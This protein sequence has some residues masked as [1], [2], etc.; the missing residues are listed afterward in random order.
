MKIFFNEFWF[1]VN[2]YYVSDSPI[3]LLVR[4]EIGETVDPMLEVGEPETDSNSEELYLISEVEPEIKNNM[5]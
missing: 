4:L 5:F 3:L 2:I 1:Y